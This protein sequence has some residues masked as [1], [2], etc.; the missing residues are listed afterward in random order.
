MMFDDDSGSPIDAC[1]QAAE[2]PGCSSSLRPA[3]SLN[4]G[5]Y[6]KL[7]LIRLSSCQMCNKQGDSIMNRRVCHGTSLFC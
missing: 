5:I 7:P 2:L 3:S 1:D 4:F 6:L